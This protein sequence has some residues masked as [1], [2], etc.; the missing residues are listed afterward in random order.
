MPPLRKRITTALVGISATA[1]IAGCSAADT[2]TDSSASPSA[3]STGATAS[4][5]PSRRGPY[6]DGEYTVDGEYGTRG[7][8]IGVAITLEGDEITAVDVIPHATDKTSRALQ[9]RFADAVPTLVAGRD[10]DD[11]R[12]DRVAGNSHTPAGFN[13]ALEKIKTEASG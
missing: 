9:R 4:G 1:A 11:V 7:S 2:E 3:A 6:E 8:S 12:L 10:I 13:D 5:S